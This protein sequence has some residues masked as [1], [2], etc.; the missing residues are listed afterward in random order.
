MT[1]WALR[2]GSCV[3]TDGCTLR[4]WELKEGVRD[5]DGPSIITAEYLRWR[6]GPSDD[7]P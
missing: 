5:P 4:P 1:I 6:E 7:V 3:R 2:S